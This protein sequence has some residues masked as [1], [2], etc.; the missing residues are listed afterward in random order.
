MSKVKDVENIAKI[1]VIGIGGG[2]NNAI[3]RII[4]DK[5][6]SKTSFRFDSSAIWIAN[7][8][9]F[10]PSIPRTASSFPDHEKRRSS[11]VVP[12]SDLAK[13]FAVLHTPLMFV[14]ASIIGKNASFN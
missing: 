10:N 12:R 7:T 1:K 9:S 13:P 4:E 2:G 11:S 3:F 5:T 8:G 14:S 6:E